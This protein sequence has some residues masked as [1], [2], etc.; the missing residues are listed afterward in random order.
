MG[1][2]KSRSTYFAKYFLR[3]DTRS[4]YLRGLWAI[5]QR[6]HDLHG[7]VRITR[8]MRA[9]FSYLRH[10]RAYGFLAAAAPVATA[11]Y[12]SVACLIAFRLVI[13]RVSRAGMP[14]AASA[15]F[16]ASVGAPG[17]SEV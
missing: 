13:R 7:L 8:G 10:R 1:Y 9:D 3:P 6:H 4:A 14:D 5:S 17:R 2:D 12:C 11:A 15:A 16:S